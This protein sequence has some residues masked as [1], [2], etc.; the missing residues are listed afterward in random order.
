M[1]D[2]V[3]DGRSEEDDFHSRET[4]PAARRPDQQGAPM[5]DASEATIQEI[6]GA[7]GLASS[8]LHIR[9][10][11]CSNQVELLEETEPSDIT[12]RSCGSVFSLI[13]PDIG[14][15]N[16][17]P[18]KTVGH[19]ELISRVGMGSFGA[20]WKAHDVQLD[21]TVAVKIPRRGRLDPIEETQF[22]RE[23]RVAAQLSHPHIV[24]VYEIGREKETLYIV[25]DFI[26]GVALSEMIAARS[27]STSETVELCAKVC[28]A[29]DHA[30]AQGVIHR[31]LKPSN[32]LMDE[33]NEPHL[34]DFGLAKRDIGELT[35]TVDGQILGTPAYMSPE[36]AAGEAHHVDRRTD[37]YS[38]GVML[39]EMLTGELPFRGS[40]QMQIHQ[41][42]TDDPPDPR[43]LTSSIPRDLAT[44]CSKCIDRNPGPRYATAAA[45]AD[46]LDRFAAGRPI[47]ARPVSRLE[48]A[49]RW[50]KRHPAP[51]AVAALVTLLAIAGPAAAWRINALLQQA[52]QER[53]KYKVAVQDREATITNYSATI[54]RL[55]RENSQLAERLAARKG[56]ASAAVFWLPSETRAAYE[57][58]LRMI[59]EDKD[60]AEQMI[61]GAADQQQ[62]AFVHLALGMAMEALEGEIDATRALS[63]FQIAGE[64]LEWLAAQQPNQKS[65]QLALADCLTRAAAL[66]LQHD[67]E[68]AAADLREA[69]SIRRRL[70]RESEHANV[71]AALMDAEIRSAQVNASEPG[72]ESLLNVAKIRS[73]L[74]TNKPSDARE[75]YELA[76]FL[77]Q[78]APALAD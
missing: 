20:V 24:S 67:R 5:D 41:K 10:P 22:I 19:F 18:L 42:L 58:L 44:I 27:F 49:I 54:D 32:I 33:Q 29:L 26:R 57:S 40:A 25:S 34:T 1:T 70:A 48:R 50:A 52:N 4:I 15:R 36:Q 30:H 74:A 45:L 68:G 16:A 46:D 23:A 71:Q 72:A 11:H 61:A 43:K 31:D 28:R 6:M 73:R 51:A 62:R 59:V 53:S 21:R 69:V 14:T 75:L 8:G 12:C 77:T 47:R 35:M 64:N 65:Y 66:K 56:Q 2:T 7:A 60:Y 55:Q 9:C 78:Q 38:V 63:H 39:F 17:A 13:D 3:A 76:C 37:I